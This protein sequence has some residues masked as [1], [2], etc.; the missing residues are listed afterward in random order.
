MLVFLPILIEP[1]QS[2]VQILLIFGGVFWAC[3]NINSLPMVLEFAS[4]RT[5]GAFTGYYYLFSFTAAITSP[6][7]FGFI[8]DTLKSNDLL[9]VYAVICFAVALFSMLFV[10]HG[11]NGD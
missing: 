7:L 6:I 11:E 5:I 9:F 8:Q 10:K 1:S 4:E 2:V 3:I